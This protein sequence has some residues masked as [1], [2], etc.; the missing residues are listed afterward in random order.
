MNN[1][2]QPDRIKATLTINLDFAKEDQPLISG[3]LQQIIDNLGLSGS[4]NGWP[5]ANSQFDYKLTHNQ[6]S[7]PVTMDRLLDLFD[8]NREPGEPT[9]RERIEESQHPEYE[10]ALDWWD[11]L[12]QAQRGWIMEKHPGLTLV[13]KAWEANKVLSPVDQN[14]FQNLK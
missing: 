3:V 8:A 9:A 14:H 4:G 10:E 11:G 5:T 2:E 7:E 6:P 1:Q 12:N 13:T